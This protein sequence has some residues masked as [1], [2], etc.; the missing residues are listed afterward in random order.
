M[1]IQDWSE[2]V[3]EIIF[4]TILD[5]ITDEKSIDEFNPPF[6][7]RGEDYSLLVALYRFRTSSLERARL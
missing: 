7:R 2:P 4:Q 3:G 6:A 1:K 5:C